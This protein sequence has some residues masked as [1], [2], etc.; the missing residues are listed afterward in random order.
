MGD[1]RWAAIV[2]I[3][4]LVGFLGGLFGKGGSAIATP[5]LAAVGVPPIVAGASPW[6][7]TLPGTLVA[8]WRYRDVGLSARDAIRWSVVIGVPATVAGALLTLWVGGGALVR[9]TDVVIAVI[10]ARVL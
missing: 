9:T 10:G 2:L 3:G 6:P 4:A 5:L 1:V 8:C 7:A